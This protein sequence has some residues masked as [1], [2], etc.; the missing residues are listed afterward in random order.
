MTYPN[1]YTQRVNGA[2][3]DGIPATTSSGPASSGQITALGPLGTFDSS[4]IPPASIGGV[5]TVNGL[6]GAVIISGGQNITIGGTGQIILVIAASGTGGGG[7]TSGAMFYAGN[8]NGT[9]A[10]SAG[11]VVIASGASYVAISNVSVPSSGATFIQA[12]SVT[13]TSKAFASNVTAGNLLVVLTSSTGLGTT[14]TPTDTLGNIYQ[15]LAN[16]INSGGNPTTG[17]FAC[18]NKLTGANTVSFAISGGILGGIAVAEFH[19][20][21]LPANV[22]TASVS[23]VVSGQITPTVI[24]TTI[25]AGIASAANGGTFGA[26]PGFTMATQANGGYCVGMDYALNLNA[27][28]YNGGF[29]GSFVGP[30]LMAAFP[31]LVQNNAPAVDTIHWVQLGMQNPMTTSGDMIY[32]GANGIPARLPIG[33]SGQKLTVVGGLPAWQ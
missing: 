32:L 12:A 1:R 9:V 25:V 33:T 3:V 6:S 8:W 20:L 22:A 16:K 27:S 23:N 19:S 5:T 24:G 30:L 31:A 15:L 29:T 26:V 10:Y 7:T 11:A 28:L 2:F 13:S 14:P 21:S 4:M 18:I 17:L